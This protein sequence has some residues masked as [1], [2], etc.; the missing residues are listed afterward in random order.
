MFPG[1]PERASRDCKEYEKLKLSLRRRF[2]HDRDG[3]TEGKTDFVREYTQK[4]KAEYGPKRF[5]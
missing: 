3:Y 1:L 4:A 5:A 2:E